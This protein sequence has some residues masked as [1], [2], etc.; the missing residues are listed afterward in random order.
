M[1]ARL[2]I[3]A[4]LAAALTGCV[5]NDAS[6]RLFGLCFPPVPGDGGSCSFPATCD[7]L[8]LGD[9][10]VDLTLTGNTFY[11]PVQ[12]DNQRPNNADRA[13]GT[14]TATAWIEEY[15]VSYTLA[16]GGTIDT[17]FPAP[18]RHPV[19]SSGSTVVV[20]PFIP[21]T[22][23]AAIAAAMGE[24]DVATA[25]RAEFRARGHYGD[26]TSFETGPFT[27][28]VSTCNSGTLATTCIRL[29]PP[30]PVDTPNLFS[31]PQF[32]QTSVSVCK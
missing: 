32:G 13:G 22:V 4:A 1:T 2:I 30:C 24:T 10:Q 15:K 12:V 18:A 3:I 5:D 9:L 28:E 23:G 25:V 19:N 29:P 17:T 16:I 6:V 21:A 7:A 26:G 8:L 27:V 20:V 11:L 14:N 31:C